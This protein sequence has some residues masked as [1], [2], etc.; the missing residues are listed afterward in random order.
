MKE[1][2]PEKYVTL[3]K[4]IKPRGKKK[5]II[6]TKIRGLVSDDAVDFLYRTLQIDPSKRI[7]AK[8]ALEHSFL[9]PLKKEFSHMNA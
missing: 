7:S 6:E 8:E 9:L 4:I 1:K 3:L 5:N 2:D